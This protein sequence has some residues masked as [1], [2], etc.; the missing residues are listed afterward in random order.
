MRQGDQVTIVARHREG[1]EDI[2]RSFPSSSFIVVADV[3][4]TYIYLNPISLPSV[5]FPLSLSR[6]PLSP[7]LSFPSR[8]YSLHPSL[9]LTLLPFSLALP[10]PFI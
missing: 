4:S 7:S 9:A 8:S 3:S 10:S 2:H 6:W 1:L 5:L